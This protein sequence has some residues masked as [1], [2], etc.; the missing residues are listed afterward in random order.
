[1][2]VAIYCRLSEEDRNKQ[3]ETD[4]SESIQNQKSMLIQYAVDREWEIHSIYSDDDYTGADRNRPEFNRLLTDAETRKFDI[5]LCKTQSRFTRELEIVEKYIH[6]L[7]PLWG[8]RFISIVD[9]ADTE[10]KGNKKSRQINGLINEWYLEDM[11]EN[12][13]S[14]LTNRRKQGFHIGAFPLYG[15][16][17]DPDKKGHLII[18]EE[19]AEVVREVFSLYAQGYGKTAIARILNDKSIPNPTTY[20]VQKGY[21][22]RKTDI[23]VSPLWKYFAI[24]DMLINEMYIGN[25]VQGKYGSISYKTKQNKPIPKKNWIKVENTHEPIISMELWETVQRKVNVNFKPFGNT[26]KIGLFAKKAKCMNCGYTMRT[27]KNRGVHYL[28]CPTKHVQKG[29]C[30]GSFIRV[31][32]LSGIVLEELNKMIAEYLDMDEM[33]Q[34]ITVENDI[35]QKRQKFLSEVGTYEKKRTELSKAIKDLY[36]DKV[37]GLITENEFVEFSKEFY[38]DKERIEKNLS[39]VHKTLDTL[40][41]EMQNTDGKRTLISQYLNVTQLDRDM[42]EK[43]IDTIYVGRKDAETK[44]LPVEINWNV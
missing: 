44:I 4:D 42:V 36:I 8:I 28:K 14:V 15:Y 30:I 40:E 25:L 24:S 12:I 16:M 29:A 19:A 26:G 27:S 13:K 17:K 18:D 43:L 23:G 35:K 22:H 11:S 9:N 34:R 32:A 38:Q 5:I 3:K 20:R 33:E 37:K 41:S 7:F 6:G 21:E 31:D 39:D 2:K 10:V 1:M